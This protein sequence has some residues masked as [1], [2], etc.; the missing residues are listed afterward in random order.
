VSSHPHLVLE[1]AGLLEDAGHNKDALLFYKALKQVPGQMDAPA[2]IQM[3]KCLLKEERN[4]EGEN[5][6]LEA[7]RIDQKNIEARVQLARL[8]E[9]IDESE[10]AFAYVNQVLDLES[11]RQPKMYRR[12]LLPPVA[13]AP[14][15]A[16]APIAPTPE[17]IAPPQPKAVPELR[18]ASEPKV[19]SRTRPVLT[20]QDREIEEAYYTGHLRDKYLILAKETDA[21]RSG[22][23]Q[24]ITVWMECARALTE[25]FRSCKAFY[26]WDRKEFDGYTKEEQHEARRALESHLA[27]LSR[28]HAKG[29]LCTFSLPRKQLTLID[30]GAEI[31][32]P[33]GNPTKYREISF[34]DWLDIFIEYALCLAGRGRSREAYDVCEAA[35]HAIIFCFSRED[36]FTLHV[37]YCSKFD[38][39]SWFS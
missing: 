9:K 36:M 13:I 3:G 30:I 34:K 25:D 21:M 24:A 22:D 12:R 15:P 10:Q 4:K 23:Y 33:D 32:D 35:I 26:P 11:A 20:E 2:L 28:R 14:K 7:A 1:V 38:A 18:Q 29:W 17:P 31:L 6:L 27:A 19:S 5:V 16:P 37:C 8:Y 39:C